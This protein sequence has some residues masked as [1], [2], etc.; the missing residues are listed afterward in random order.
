MQSFT[1]AKNLHTYISIHICAIT[2]SSRAS[3]CLK[4][5]LCSPKNPLCQKKG[6]MYY[7]RPLNM[8]GSSFLL[9]T[10]DR[11]KIFEKEQDDIPVPRPERVLQVAW[12]WHALCTKQ[13][14]AIWINAHTDPWPFISGNLKGPFRLVPSVGGGDAVH[15]RGKDCQF[16][17]SVG[18]WKYM[19]WHWIYLLFGNIISL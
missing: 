19:L 10:K 14:N 9:H 18:C 11:S 17:L 15:F 5:S 8:S 2:P 12:T 7:K 3:G 13:Q 4:C 6:R 1:A 16:F